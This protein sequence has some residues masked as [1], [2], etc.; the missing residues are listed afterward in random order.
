MSQRAGHH[1]D[2]SRTR[3]EELRHRIARLERAG[4]RPCPVCGFQVYSRSQLHPQCAAFR[5]ESQR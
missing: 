4:K 2:T 5:E 1:N 3:L